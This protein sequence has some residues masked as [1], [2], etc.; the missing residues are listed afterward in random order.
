MK[1]QWGYIVVGLFLT[2]DLALK[3]IEKEPALSDN[4]NKIVAN[5]IV[6]SPTYFSMLV[7]E[8]DSKA[9]TEKGWSGIRC[10][11]TQ[12]NVG[13]FHKCEKVDNLFTNKLS[14]HMSDISMGTSK[15]I[16]F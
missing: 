13:L 1:I 15:K 16:P 8:A 5:L 7:E 3:N 14:I 9:Q 6:N 4:S 2:A 12:V 11:Y 10:S